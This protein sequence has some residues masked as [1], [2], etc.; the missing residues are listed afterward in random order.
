MLMLVD[1]LNLKRN[2]VFFQPWNWFVFIFVCISSFITSIRRKGKASKKQEMSKVNSFLPVWQDGTNALI[3]SVDSSAARGCRGDVETADPP[4][5]KATFPIRPFGGISKACGGA[6]QTNPWQSGNEV[7]FDASICFDKPDSDIDQ[8]LDDLL[9]NHGNTVDNRSDIIK[10]DPVRKQYL[11]NA[12]PAKIFSRSRQRSLSMN[13]EPNL[14]IHC[15]LLTI[16]D[17]NR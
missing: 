8:L 5:L 13:Q 4:K 7:R 9:T 16:N 17:M 11:V 14:T 1:Y 12:P 10:Y 3:D 6:I 2:A 15:T